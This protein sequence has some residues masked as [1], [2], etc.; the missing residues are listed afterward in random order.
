MGKA[1]EILSVVFMP[2]DQ[3][4]GI[5]KPGKEAFDLPAPPRAT[6]GSA[7]LRT[8]FTVRVMPR[9]HFDPVGRLKMRIKPVAVVPPIANQSRGE[10][11]EERGRERGVDE[12]DFRRR[13]RGHG[14]SQRNTLTDRKSVV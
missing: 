2:G 9:D 12:R 6:N 4:P 7:V 5:M 14:D 11:V 3:T 8:R 10:R 13:R 1:E